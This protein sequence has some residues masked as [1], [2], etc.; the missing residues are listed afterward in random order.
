MLYGRGSKTTIESRS[1]HD[2]DGR[3][4]RGAEPRADREESALEHRQGRE[5]FTVVELPPSVVD[6]E[7]VLR[8]GPFVSHFRVSKASKPSFSDS[9]AVKRIRAPRATNPV[10]LRSFWALVDHSGSTSETVGPAMRMRGLEPPR[11]SWVR[12]GGWRQLADPAPLRAITRFGSRLAHALET[13]FGHGMG[14][15][16]DRRVAV[17][18]V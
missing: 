17:L 8:H 18:R 3:R 7:R 4:T 12:G 6:P 14:T 9:H 15:P 1:A 13:A 10:L 5:T 2:E 11:G 16:R